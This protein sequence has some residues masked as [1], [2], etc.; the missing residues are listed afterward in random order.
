MVRLVALGEE[1]LALRDT[2]ER[3]AA[4]PESGAAE[5]EEQQDT[6]KS[7]LRDQMLDLAQTIANTHARSPQELTYKA[8]VALDWIDSEG[9]MA[10][11]LACSLCRDVIVLF[12]AKA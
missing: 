3:L 5:R 9:D 6:M 2:V 1:F 10:D 4:V 11:L 12:P 8:R 7:L